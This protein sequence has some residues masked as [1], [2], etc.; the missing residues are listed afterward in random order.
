MSTDDGVGDKEKKS[1]WEG[2]AGS[3]I[4]EVARNKVLTGK[5]GAF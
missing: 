3:M 4:Y 5:R 1:T 2:K